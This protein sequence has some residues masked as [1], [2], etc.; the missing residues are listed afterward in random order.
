MSK[1]PFSWTTFLYEQT[2]K[3]EAERENDA[4]NR[5]KAIAKHRRANLARWKRR[6]E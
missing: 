1:P 5:R 4:A 3:R 6:K 2:R